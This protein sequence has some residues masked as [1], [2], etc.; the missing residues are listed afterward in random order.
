LGVGALYKISAEFEFGGHSPP[1]V[2][3]QKCGVGLQRW[4]NQRGL[5][6]FCR[7]LS[8]W[9]N[10]VFCRDVLAA[11]ITGLHSVSWDC[12]LWKVVG[13]ITDCRDLLRRFLTADPEQRITLQ[14]AMQ[15]AWISGST[16]MTILIQQ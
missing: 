5:C 7:R 1:G 16:S 11:S 14:Q 12:L 4:E 15:H 10:S 6:S 9:W 13:V 3:L 8:S 2:H